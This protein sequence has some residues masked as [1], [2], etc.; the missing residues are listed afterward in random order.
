M[1]GPRNPTAVGVVL[2]LLLFVSLTIVQ[3]IPPN[4]VPY[5][6]FDPYTSNFTT[7][8]CSVPN[9]NLAN[10][11][12]RTVQKL[13]TSF[14]LAERD[15]LFLLNSVLQISNPAPAPQELLNKYA[16][17]YG[18]ILHNV[19]LVVFVPT[20]VSQLSKLMRAVKVNNFGVQDDDDENSSYRH[21]ELFA[22]IKVVIRGAGGNVEAAA[23][24]LNIADH[25]Q[26]VPPL[27]ILIDM[28]SR[29]TQVSDTIQVSAANQKSIWALA[30]A[31]W[32][33]VVRAAAAHNLRPLVVPDYLGITLGGSLSIGGIGADSVF[34][35]PAAAHVAELEI[36]KSDGDVVNVTSSSTLFKSVLGG[37][38]QFG[39]ISR[40]RL[41]LEPN[42]AMTRIYHYVSTD[43][44]VLV[45]A[46]DQ[47][48]IAN[49][50]N[51]VV[52][53]IQTFFVPDTL[54]YI[55]IWALNG[56]TTYRSPQ[57]QAQVEA[58]LA[59]N[60][61]YVFM[62][63]ITT[64]FDTT[65]PTMEEIAALT[66]QNFDLSVVDDMPTNIWDERLFY[67]T[68]PGLI[69]SGQWFERH[70]WMNI[71]LAGDVFERDPQTQQSDFDRLI[72]DWTPQKTTGFGHV[73]LYPLLNSQFNSV[74][75]VSIPKTSKWSYLLV[76]GRDEPTNTDAGINYQVY[77]N[78]RI[79]DLF[80][81]TTM[82]QLD[83]PRA[84]LYADNVIPNF[85]RSDWKANFGNCVWRDFV[86][87]K[88]EFDP[89]RVFADPRNIFKH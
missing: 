40:V 89:K 61:T 84:T 51:E 49:S 39:I 88:R 46:V 48:Q 81:K 4:F 59:K 66:G 15:D 53:T 33:S 2:A 43:F 55:Q 29:F 80:T 16:E 11:Y 62:L 13:L 17:D 7:V 44:D 9:A 68:I 75:F 79:W 64:R 73:G 24:V 45:K 69:A 35:G 78:R 41:N 70:P 54:F 38:G 57:E 74:P 20:Q 52:Q 18:H 30:G 34:R 85:R 10:I 23:Q 21:H 76:I 19:P 25:E 32:V 50:Q 37:M 47:L 67:F 83:R 12:K 56:R 5:S 82:F 6:A 26:A 8:P 42:K 22:R 3:A 87:A 86:A 77:D 27:Y 36:V 14:T 60:L 1:A 58:L 63:E 28:G 65:A 31:Q 72:A 71:Y